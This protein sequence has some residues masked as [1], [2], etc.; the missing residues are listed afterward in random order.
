MIIQYDRAS[1]AGCLV[2]LDRETGFRP[3]FGT[4]HRA[5]IGLTEQT[6]ALIVTVSEENGDISFCHK[7]RLIRDLVWI[8]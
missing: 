8:V 7:G 3:S 4:R 5:A 2:P 6:D 1:Y